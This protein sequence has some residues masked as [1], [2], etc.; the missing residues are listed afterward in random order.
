MGPKCK[1]F[2]QNKWESMSIWPLSQNSININ[3]CMT[4]T[5]DKELW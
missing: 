3:I 1:L 2:L 5:Y 4:I